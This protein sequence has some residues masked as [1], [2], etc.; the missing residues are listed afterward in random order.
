LDLSKKLTVPVPVPKA[1]S[2]VINTPFANP[3]GVEASGSGSGSSF[4]QLV[5]VIAKAIVAK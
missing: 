2:L 4:L 1:P 5:N 3:E